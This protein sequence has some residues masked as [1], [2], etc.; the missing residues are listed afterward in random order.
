MNPM[1][2][3]LTTNAMI[4]NV[5]MTVGIALLSFDCPFDCIVRSFLPHVFQCRACLP[6]QLGTFVTSAR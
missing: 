1:L 2:N 3:A 5:T 6:R 4:E